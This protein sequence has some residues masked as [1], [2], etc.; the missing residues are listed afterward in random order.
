MAPFHRLASGLLLFLVAAGTVRAA[1]IA[2]GIAAVVN[3]KV[4]PYS[5]VTKRVEDTERIL[6]ET[7][8]GPELVSRI[9]EARLNALRALIERELIIQDFK[10][11]G[12]F[13]PDTIIE[14]R[15]HNTI[16]T[17]YE[18]DRT[19]FIR[20]IQAQ[21]LSLDQFKDELRNSVIVQAMRS[22]NVSENV[23]ISPYKV[24]QYYQDNAAQF[25]QEGQVRLGI[26]YL[27]KSLFPKKDA[28]GQEVDPTAEIAKELLFKLDT[29]ANFADLAR[30]YSEGPKRQEGGDIGWVKRGDLRAEISD[31]AFDLQ[32]GQTSR[33]ITSSDGYYIVR[34][35][36]R[37][38]PQVQPMS[39]VRAQIEQALVEEDRQRLQLEWLDRLRAKA[40]I[41]TAF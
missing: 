22:K 5:E 4:I 8:N 2:D 12:Y 33:V 27:R 24:E 38:R 26:I 19:A 1:H 14:D 7:Y 41:K 15:L 9:K 18:G 36:D 16:Q 39:E 21:G 28:S 17:Q 35:E 20:T 37:K 32:P 40:F 6:R 3:D 29:G 34:V 10:K 23:V 11:Q 13:I 31:V 30:S 25:T